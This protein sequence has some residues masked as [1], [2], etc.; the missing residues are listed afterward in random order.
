[1]ENVYHG[2][3]M[4]KSCIGFLQNLI[5]LKGVEF[6]KVEKLIPN[7]LNLKLLGM[8]KRGKLIKRTA[9]ELLKELQHMIKLYRQTIRRSLLLNN[10]LYI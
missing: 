7:C 2:A 8:K 6:N 1:M 9:R 3:H 4:S 10:R 5:K